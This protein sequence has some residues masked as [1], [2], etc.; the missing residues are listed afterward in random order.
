MPGR[1]LLLGPHIQ[2]HDLA[3][4]HAARQLVGC[5]RFEVV[6]LTEE[7]AH[8]PVHLGEMLFGGVAQ[9]QHQADNLGPGQPVVHEQSLAAGQHELGLPQLLQMTRCVGDRQARL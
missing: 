7:I 6:T 1:V 8:D 2:H 9:G 3:I 4:G 5:H